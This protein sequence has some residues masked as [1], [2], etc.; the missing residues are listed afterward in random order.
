[1]SKL[2]FNEMY[3][4]FTQ[5]LG[6]ENK[7]LDYLMNQLPQERLGSAIIAQAS[8]Q[9]AFDEAARFTRDRKALGTSVFDFQNTR[10]LLADIAVKLQVGWAHL[11]WAITRQI[12][13]ELT[14]REATAARLWHSEI[15]F[16]LC[17]A[18]PN[19]NRDDGYGSE[20]SIGQLWR[21][22]RVQRIYG[23]NA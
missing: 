20:Y 16:E 7:A 4:P 10:L 19:L 9:R 13:K 1:M 18:A 12:A 22:A 8:A 21:D 6:E 17:D 11:D 15:Q 23:G 3:V 14:V 2:I 5:R